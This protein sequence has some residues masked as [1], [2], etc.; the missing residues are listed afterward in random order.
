MGSPKDLIEEE[1]RAH[2]EAW[3]R[4]DYLQP[5]APRHHVRIT[6]PYWLGVTGVTQEEYQKV[7]GSNPSKFKDP[8]RPVEQVSWEEAVEF[9]Q[10]LSELAG[11]KSAKRRYGLPTEAQWE[12]ACRA[13]NEGRRWFSDQSGS[14]PPALE[15]KLLEEYA[16]FRELGGQTHPV[17]MKK[18][19]AFGLY[20]MYGNVQTWCQDRYN[21]MYYATS[22]TDDPTGPPVGS[23]HV[24]WRVLELSGISAGR[25]TAA[26]AGPGTAGRSWAS[27]FAWFRRRS[28]AERAEPVRG[29]WRRPGRGE[30][31]KASAR[32]YDGS[33][34]TRG[35][36]KSPGTGWSD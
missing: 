28:R 3:Y 7:M 2:S 25:R 19:N 35:A 10:R 11:E 14:V 1:L 36:D 9:C 30:Q 13:G 23:E 6:K 34:S 21:V 15:E 18:P 17:G 27:A 26:A 31:T 33:C 24:P 32:T 4:E 12:Y 16:W 5:E 20:D 8:K 22:P 29:T